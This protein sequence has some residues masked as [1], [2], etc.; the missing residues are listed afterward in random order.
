[1]LSSDDER[2][3]PHF[4]LVLVMRKKMKIEQLKYFFRS[5]RSFLHGLRPEPEG[6]VLLKIR[7]RSSD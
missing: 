2:T 3:E 4:S 1:M 7:S 5:K 6:F